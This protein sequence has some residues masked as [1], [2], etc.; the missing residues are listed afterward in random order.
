MSKRMAALPSRSFYP[1]LTPRDHEWGLHI[2]SA[3]SN[4]IPAG[5]PEIGLDATWD[6]LPP[7]WYQ[8][9]TGPVRRLRDFEL[10]YLVHG[11]GKFW[12]AE[13]RESPVDAGHAL[14]LLPGQWHHYT[15]LQET[16]W[17]EYWVFFGGETAQRLRRNGF[18][19]AKQPVLFGGRDDALI[20]HFER[21]LELCQHR[22]L[23]FQME[24]GACLLYL[25]G[26]LLGSEQIRHAQ[27]NP[28]AEAI[29]DAID[30]LESNPAES[31]DI[32][33]LAAELHL[34]YPHFRRVFKEQTG[35]SPHQ[36]HLQVKLNQAKAMLNHSAFSISEIS[37]RIGFDDAH[38]FSRLFHK[39]TG[40][41]PSEWRG[42][43]EI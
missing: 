13:M 29:R 21:I 17:S 36:Y 1:T 39:K 31:V 27:I 34:S 22:P 11:K 10:V 37:E 35:L 6:S 38:Y 30:Y 42:Q 5:T 26:R 41:T 16:G 9:S 24:A 40:L 8:S 12:D 15:Y 28:T 43:K 7:E 2:L 20:W 18:L 19:D 4:T 3:G 33:Q 25:L 14:L 32:Q 23:G